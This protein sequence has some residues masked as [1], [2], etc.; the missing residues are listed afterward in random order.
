MNMIPKASF[1]SRSI[2]R[3]IGRERTLVLLPKQVTR[4]LS[5]TPE[6]MQEGPFEGCL[7]W[8]FLY[9]GPFVNVPSRACCYFTLTPN[10]FLPQSY[11]PF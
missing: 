3:A 5:F 1:Y 6:R 7:D 9:Y 8:G 11:R 10:F 2:I 4:S